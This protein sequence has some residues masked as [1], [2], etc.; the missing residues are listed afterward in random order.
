NSGRSDI[1]KRDLRGDAISKK[2]FVAGVCSGAAIAANW[3]GLL[4]R[5]LVLGMR[6]EARLKTS[7]LRG[8]ET[9]ADVTQE[10]RWEFESGPTGAAPAP[11]AT[12]TRSNGRTPRPR[13]QSKSVA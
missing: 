12:P 2:L 6:G 4:K 13:R 10:A 3:R 1:F 11:T 9:V 7:M 8:I 5:S